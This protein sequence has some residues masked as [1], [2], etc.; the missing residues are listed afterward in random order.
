[1]Q[2]KEKKWKFFGFCCVLFACLSCNF[3]LIKNSYATAMYA[4][5]TKFNLIGSGNPECTP[6]YQQCIFTLTGEKNVF[7]ATITLNKEITIG[8]GERIIINGSIGFNSSA[9]SG[10]VLNSYSVD[11]G[12]KKL[13][14]INKDSEMSS[15]TEDV[16]TE[17]F[18]L[19]YENSGE[20]FSTNTLYLTFSLKN[21]TAFI[22]FSTWHVFVNEQK[23]SNK[24]L[25][26]LEKSEEKDEQDRKNIENQKN[27]SNT[28]TSDAENSTNQA[29]ASLIDT[30]TSVIGAITGANARSSCVLS[31][32]LNNAMTENFSVDLCGIEPPPAL[33]AILNIPMC[34]VIFGL[35][36][37][38]YH[39][40]TNEIEGFTH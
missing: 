24:Y 40:L 18:T 3:G 14:L 5:S 25:Q 6:T 38:L 30:M 12:G 4:Y 39:R 34:L 11:F 27:D 33:I 1:M 28:T 32:K 15:S 37:S 23:I 26:N 19:I 36:R 20:E 9:F 29:T 21:E 22:V 2:F 35:C 16:K 7:G 31:G 8:K 13:T 17:T 10:F